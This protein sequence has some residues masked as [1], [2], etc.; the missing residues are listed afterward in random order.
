MSETSLALKIGSLI[1]GLGVYLVLFK[2]VKGLK[3]YGL[4]SLFY[5]VLASLILSLSTLLAFFSSTASEIKL[6][7]FGQLFIIFCGIL[8]LV[9]ATRALPWYREQLF[10]VKIGFVFC[11]LLFAYFFS[12]LSF[13]FLVSTPAQFVWH[14][15]LLW[16][17]VPILL[18]Q[19]I[20]CLL[21][22][23]P[24]KFKKWEYPV[25]EYIDDPSDE[26]M[27]N[28]VVISFVFQKNMHDPE[29]TTFRA[30]APVGMALG[31]LFYFF[32]NDYNS[33]NPESA[34]SYI[35]ESNEPDQWIFFKVRSK[36]FR[37]KEALDPDDSIYHSNIRENDV[38]IC[39]RVGLIKKLPENE[40]T[41]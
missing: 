2:K 38:L 34:I 7:V 22:V 36:L 11:I 9:I 15:S 28:P 20:I 29:L 37:L 16:F 24:K 17:L 5:V 41:K 4:P 13:S 18:N 35:N 23:P 3:K 26:E 10:A 8:H 31:R 6:L 1:L 32:V 25:N 19:S 21:E 12:N 40:T 30:K 14:L 27:E 33:M 39:N